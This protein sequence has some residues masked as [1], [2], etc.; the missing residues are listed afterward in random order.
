MHAPDLHVISVISN[1][2]RYKSRD[3]LFR[4]FAQ[5]Q[6]IT[7]V[8]QWVVEATFGERP[9]QHAQHDNPRHIVLRCDHEV[10]TKEAM[11]NAAV[12]RLPPD[13]KYVMWLDADVEFIR[14]DWA[15]E[16]IQALQH[17]AVV[18][19]FSH[20]VDL[21]PNHEVLMTHTGFAYQYSKGA[22][23]RPA[24]NPHWHPGYCWAWRRDAWNAVGGMIDFAIAGAGDHHMACAMIGKASL[25]YPP[26]GLHPNYIKRVREW[27]HR[28]EKYIQRNIGHVAG[29]I[30][31]Y[32]HG[33]K[34]DR[35]YK[36][37]WD[38]LKSNR[39]DPDHD[40]T[41]DWQGMPT[42]AHDARGLRDDLRRYFRERNEDSS[43][44]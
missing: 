34:K 15:V 35:K 11:I 36:E 28:A 31:H 19:P 16:V 24:Y 9:A 8:T 18:Q 13:W 21:G 23:F 40:L 1:P 43:E 25:S 22:E 38:I 27:E 33:A 3:R 10:W 30:L 5:R 4:E 12:R 37:R 42:I 26:D 39:F 32:F 44:S 41:H 20:A 2:V 6:E 29:S 17:Y 7:G 14:E